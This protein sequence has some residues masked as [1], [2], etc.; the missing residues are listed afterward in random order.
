MQSSQLVLPEQPSEIN[1]KSGENFHSEQIQTVLDR[2]HARNS[3]I[4]E[5]CVYLDSKMT[6]TSR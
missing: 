4:I 1:K 6:S 5:E 2:H 3:I